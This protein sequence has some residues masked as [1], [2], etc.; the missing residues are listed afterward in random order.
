MEIEGEY[1]CQIFQYL[2]LK[3]A[4]LQDEYR[5]VVK[6]LFPQEIISVDKLWVLGERLVLAQVVYPT[7]GFVPLATDDGIPLIA[8]VNA[9]GLQVPVEYLCNPETQEQCPSRLWPQLQ[10]PQQYFKWDVP[11]HQDIPRLPHSSAYLRS[12]S[13]LV[14]PPKWLPHE[15]VATHGKGEFWEH[16]CRSSLHTGGGYT[17]MRPN[18]FLVPSV[19]ASPPLNRASQFQTCGLVKGLWPSMPRSESFHAGNIVLG[20]G[21]SSSRRIFFNP[22]ADAHKCREVP[23]DSSS[24][25]R[26]FAYETPYMQFQRSLHPLAYSQFT[27]HT[28]PL[29]NGSGSLHQ[30][31]ADTTDTNRRRDYPLYAVCDDSTNNPP[32]A[33]G[34]LS[35]EKTELKHKQ[36]FNHGGI[37]LKHKCRKSFMKRLLNAFRSEK[38]GEIFNENPKYLEQHKGE[39]FWSKDRLS[40]RNMKVSARKKNVIPKPPQK[41][42]RYNA[43]RWETVSALCHSLEHMCL[44]TKHRRKG[45]LKPVERTVF[46]STKVPDISIAA[47][48]K[49]IAWFSECSKACFVLAL[50]YIHRLVKYKPHMEVSYNV[51]HQL[52][53]TCIMVATKFFD[54]RFFKNSFYARVGGVQRVTL[55][56]FEVQLLFFLNFDFHLLPEQYDARHKAMLTDNQGSSKVTIGPDGDWKD[57]VGG[58]F[59]EVDFSDMELSPDWEESSEST[60]SQAR[61]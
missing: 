1:N 14:I 53:L 48:L 32:N 20:S 45:C 21:I 7:S 27:S 30:A 40:P 9:F 46:Y 26:N 37:P 16:A 43:D 52:I 23:I 58:D 61:Y 3:P 54:D 17:P 41:K 22:E 42:W 55:S 24:T 47:Y 38:D 34:F 60:A 4:V 49:R 31:Q 6:N 56:G 29:V 36:H 33:A 5:R 13:N 59:S 18:I 2:V 39:T 28:G 15:Q 25:A 51:V 11:S 44:K 8:R 19:R 50:E 57:A 35:L 10:Y 12:L